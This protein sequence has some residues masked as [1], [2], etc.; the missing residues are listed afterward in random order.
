MGFAI[1]RD[2]RE[3][4]SL[5]ATTTCIGRSQRSKKFT[6]APWRDPDPSDHN[7]QQVVPNLDR[8]LALHLPDL[9]HP[10]LRPRLTGAVNLRYRDSDGGL[11]GTK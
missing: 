3:D 6:E 1:P 11:Q 10:L 7:L 4:S 8:A 2:W 9:T 5:S